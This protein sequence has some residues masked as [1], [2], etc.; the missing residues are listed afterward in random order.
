MQCEEEY[1][2]KIWFVKFLRKLTTIYV[3]FSI[4][5]ERVFLL[6]ICSYIPIVCIFD[7]YEYEACDL[8]KT[9]QIT[10]NLIEKE[11]EKD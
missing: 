4:V 10:K 5:Y 7:F 11:D 9:F 1:F 6:V 8:N 2:H 3:H